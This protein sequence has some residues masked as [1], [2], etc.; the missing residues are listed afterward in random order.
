M[1]QIYGIDLSK[2]KF[3]L[4]FR[5]ENGRKRKKEVKNTYPAIC[6]FLSGLEKDS[7]LC[8]EHT[9]VYGDLL[10]F[11]A[12][13]FGIKI[14]ATPGYVIKHSLGLQKGKS[15]E[16]DADRIREHGERFTDKLREAWL[17]SENIQELRELNNLRALLVEQR[18]MLDTQ[19]K[20]KKHAVYCSIKSH[21]VY[22]NMKKSLDDQIR[23]LEIEIEK[24]IRKDEQMQ[25]NSE[26]VQ[27]IIGI[28][29]VTTHELIIKTHNF[30]KIATARQAASYAGVCP[31]PDSSGKMVKK[32]KVSKMRDKSL[33]KLLYLCAASAIQYNKD[34]KL[35][36]EKKIGEGKPGYLVL[37]N[38][39][40]KLLRTIYALLETRQMYDPNY[41]CM[42]PR[43]LDK[44]VA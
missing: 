18:K 21:Q 16:L 34:M 41:I 2:G 14:Y 19:N 44:N 39:A 24:I 13:Y 17:N 29:P 31:F 5:S 30:K 36:Y 32:S 43:I 11:L 12:N 28:G 8:I 42:D 6:K 23:D 10:I 25:Q 15:D 38:V 1:E 3:D 27:S 20:D 7:M 35:Y 22:K 4:S 40:N 37:N 33:K 9:G 26:I